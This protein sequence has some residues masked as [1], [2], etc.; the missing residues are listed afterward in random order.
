MTQHRKRF[1]IIGGFFILFCLSFSIF[2]ILFHSQAQ[3]PKQP[4][5]PEEVHN[6]PLPESSL[7]DLSGAELQSS[8]L[9]RGKVVLVMAT[10]ECSLCLEESR[11]L[12][13]LVNKRSDVRFYGVVPYGIDKEVLKDA[14]DKFPFKVFFDEGYRLRR[15]LKVNRVPVKIYLEDGIVKK[16][17][18]G[19]T[20]FFHAEEEFGEWLQAL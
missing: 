17:W 18:V 19:S 14:A 2:F 12:S 4:S 16:T 11:F 3:E 8:E 13:T 9:R 15:A 5:L 1:A 7:V 10:S 6:R 20:P